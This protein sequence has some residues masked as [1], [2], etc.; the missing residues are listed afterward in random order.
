MRPKD[1]SLLF[2]LIL[3]L[4]TALSL[5]PFEEPQPPFIIR[6]PTDI[7]GGQY[8]F[9]YLKVNTIDANYLYNRY[10]VNILQDANIHGDLNVFGNVGIAGAIYGDNPNGDLNILNPVFLNSNLTVN[11]NVLHVDTAT[12]RV[13]IGTATPAA[14]LDV[15]GDI[16][17]SNN[18]EIERQGALGNHHLISSP[19]NNLVIDVSG[20][21]NDFIIETVNGS[22]ERFR[23]EGDTGNVGIGTATPAEKLH[24]AGANGEAI[25]Q[26]S[27]NPAGQYTARQVAHFSASAPE[28][29]WYQFEVCDSTTT[30]R[31]TPLVLYGDKT[32]YFSGDVGIGIATP[33]GKLHVKEGTSGATPNVNIDTGVF[34]ASQEGGITV[35]TPN[36]K[37]ARFA[38]GDPE[39]NYVAGMAYDHSVDD[40]W[41]Y[42]NNARIMTID[43]A[44]NVGVKH[45]NPGVLSGGFDVSNY[46]VVHNWGNARSYLIQRGSQYVISLWE[47]T[48]GTAGRRA[49]QTTF[50]GDKVTYLFQ[51]A[52]NGATYSNPLTLLSSGHV[53]IGTTIP[54]QLLNVAGDFN[55]TGKAYFMNDMSIA[56]DLNIEGKA[57]FNGLKNFNPNSVLIN[58]LNVT[59]DSN[60]ANISVSNRTWLNGNLFMGNNAFIAV[61][62]NA[63]ITAS[64]T[65]TQGQGA[66]S[67]QV[68]EIST[69]ANDDDTVTLPP[70]ITGITVEIINNGANTLLIFPASGNDLGLGIN[71]GEELEANERVK[72]VA[73]TATKW[74]KESTTEIIHAEIHDEDNTDAFIINDTGGDFH[75]YHTNGLASGDLADWEFDAG[76]AGTSHAI[77]SIVDIGGGDINVTTGDAHELEVG[78]I[79]SQTNLADAAYVGIFT[80]LTV[81]TTTV[82]T[83]TAA[84]TATGTGTLDQAATL[85]ADAV[86][87]GVYDF[88]YYISATPVGN[89]E[90]FDFQLYNETTA[91]IGSKIRRKFGAG[92]DFGSMS[93]GGVIAVANGDK[94]SFALSNEDSAANLIIRNITIVL[95]RL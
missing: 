65:Q 1:A 68:N 66:L 22:T 95:I 36:D 10:D 8:D 59:G 28:N 84:Y 62:V 15:V 79:I 55:T 11:T 4:P 52:V 26:Y 88:A 39:D 19:A 74:A 87:A 86:A 2:A 27:Y 72:F 58:D 16:R 90:T 45:N 92:G 44:G 47:N 13:G 29:N 37:I 14:E 5:W 46:D 12:R 49:F 70:A 20:G 94:I 30:G 69:V 60:F 40:M 24:V 9:D 76:G 32:A 48:G 3:L 81:P 23:I 91:I 61:D 53:G 80:V 25:I 18:I 38:F 34:E 7:N 89:N 17:T 50:T 75:S 63:G 82:Y 33:S 64:T 54:Q 35:L 83:I 42:A 56:G 73:Y 21:A 71:I 6:L 78:D 85:E 43:D 67:S 51:S 77:T 57:A 31:V 93:G 41:F